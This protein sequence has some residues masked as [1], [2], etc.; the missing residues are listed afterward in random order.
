MDSRHSSPENAP[1]PEMRRLS[2]SSDTAKSGFATLFDN[3]FPGHHWMNGT[4]I[5]VR[6]WFREHERK[7][8]AGVER[9]RMKLL[10]RADNGVRYIVLI[11]PHDGRALGDGKLLRTERKVVDLDL[12]ARRIGCSLRGQNRSPDTANN[13]NEQYGHQE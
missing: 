4:E 11:R 8:V 5:F 10:M 13:S 1:Q 12:L 3:D 2:I 6:T 9:L 7:L